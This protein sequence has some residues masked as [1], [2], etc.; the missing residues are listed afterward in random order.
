MSRPGTEKD[1]LQGDA[2]EFVPQNP[3]IGQ[4]FTMQHGST[5]SRGTEQDL[6]VHD[7]R[8]SW[9]GTGHP[10]LLRSHNA[11]NF[12]GKTAPVQLLMAHINGKVMREPIPVVGYHLQP[13]GWV[14]NQ[15][16][17]LFQETGPTWET[18]KYPA[19]YPHGGLYNTSGQVS[20]PQGPLLHPQQNPLQAKRTVAMWHPG[21]IWQYDAVQ[22]RWLPPTTDFV[23][24]QIP[25]QL[26]HH[27]YTE[28]Q[29][30][31][32]ARQGENENG[33]LQQQRA[34]ISTKPT[35]RVPLRSLRPNQQVRRGRK[36]E[37]HP[38]PGMICY[39][40]K[41]IESQ[42]LREQVKNRA[43]YA[44]ILGHPV[45]VLALCAGQPDEV[46]F[47]KVTTFG[48]KTAEQKFG[49]SDKTARRFQREYLPIS[50]SGQEKEEGNIELQVENGRRMGARSWVN[51]GPKNILRIETRHLPPFRR[52]TKQGVE[53]SLTAD[54]LKKLMEH[55][56]KLVREDHE[57]KRLT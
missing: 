12:D 41:D 48:G 52:T 47:A 24:R 33:G 43:D 2:D 45:V 32:N 38:V 37:P 30:T 51:I 42:S 46:V 13:A 3:G 56:W 19:P 36:A 16:R 31:R 22:P 54:S 8:Q 50:H 10:N 6:P 44:E 26:S 40:H 4:A 5:R 55:Y 1:G 39:L 27:V 28:I 25:P 53:Y 35:G 57:A 15:Q 14:F 29:P 18:W 49:G 34:Q 20:L 7:A 17:Y 11:R 23:W 21:S 9:G